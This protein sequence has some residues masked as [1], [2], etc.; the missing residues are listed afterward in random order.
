MARDSK[1]TFQRIEKLQASNSDTKI[2][3]SDQNI[4]QFGTNRIS[5]IKAKIDDNGKPFWELYDEYL[6]TL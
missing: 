1:T 5:E 3:L 4:A 6:D 2:Y